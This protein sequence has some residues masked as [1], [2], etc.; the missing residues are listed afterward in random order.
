MTD[1]VLNSLYSRSNHFKE[2]KARPDPI[3]H[4]LQ[5]I[6]LRAKRV[7]DMPTNL[8]HIS[9]VNTQIKEQFAR[10]RRMRSTNPQQAN[11]LLYLLKPE[12]LEYQQNISAIHS[13]PE[14]LPTTANEEKI[15]QPGLYACFGRSNHKSSNNNLLISDGNARLCQFSQAFQYYLC[16]PGFHIKDLQDKLDDILA[17]IDIIKSTYKISS[18]SAMLGFKD[19][20]NRYMK[21]PWIAQHV[22]HEGNIHKTVTQAY[23]ILDK[24]DINPLPPIPLPKIYMN[25]VWGY[26]QVNEVEDYS[27]NYNIILKE[28]ALENDK[29]LADK[30][31]KQTIHPH[32]HHYKG[33]ALDQ[34]I[35]AINK[36]R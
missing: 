32:D 28:L 26:S 23:H 29:M 2:L 21:P 34:F 4:A 17:V 25:D 33:K 10:L 8:Q 9:K 27:Y 18:V 5:I 6:T 1:L 15:E 11:T 35:S 19:L 3:D 13:L 36:M 14:N 30:I 7:W 24:Y 20:Q 12:S 31:S 16:L 22:K